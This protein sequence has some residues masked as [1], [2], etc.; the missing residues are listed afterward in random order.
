MEFEF[1]R[2]KKDIDLNKYVI[3]TYRLQAKDNAKNASLELAIG[4]SVGNPSVRNEWETPELFEKHSCLILESPLYLEN[5]KDC[6]VDIAFPVCNTNWEY[7]GI[8]HLLCQL[9]GGQLDID[10]I[11]RC[12]LLDIQIPELVKQYFLPPKYGINGIRKYTECY[13]KPVLGSIIKPKIGLNPNQL[14]DMV[15]QL[16][17]GGVNFIKEDEIMA[18]PTNCSIYN[19]VELIGRYLENVKPKV[20]YATCI[21]SD[22]QY[23]LNKLYTTHQ[24]GVNGIHLN[25]WSGLGSY[26][27]L[28]RQDLPLFIHFQKS[29]DKILTDKSHRFRIDW[30][31]IC[32]LACLSGVDFIHTGMWGGYNS[33]DEEDLHKHINFL[34]QNNVMPVL[35]CGMHPGLVNSIT[36]KFGV[37]YMANTGGAIHG[38]PDGTLAGAKA[39]RQAIDGDFGPEYYKAID[40]WG[41]VE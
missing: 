1:F 2:D 22:P 16:V 18:N 24:Y 36:D 41:L 9:M 26:N 19:R 23:L 28:R 6:L 33:E 11:Q 32:K 5:T 14:L 8:S 34:R 10:N 17:D 3:A 20:I 30:Y 4:Q 13:N 27:V 40:K 38:H 37:D 35:S 15:K 31:V 7:D 12:E 29:G 25:F 21:N 39:M